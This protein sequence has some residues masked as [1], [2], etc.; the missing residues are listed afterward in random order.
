MK[1]TPL[2]ELLLARVQVLQH[3]LSAAIRAMEAEQIKVRKASERIAR[4]DLIEQLDSVL[5]DRR[6]ERQP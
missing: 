5:L 2:E 1:Y 6:T 4:G 3:A